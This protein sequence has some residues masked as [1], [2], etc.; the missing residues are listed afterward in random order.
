MLTSFQF[1][2]TEYKVNIWEGQELEPTYGYL[3]VDTETHL[4][5]EWTETPD[6]VTFQVFDGK[7]AYYLYPYQVQDFLILH[8]D[9][10]LVFHN[11]PF[12]CDVICKLV[13]DSDFF[14][15]MIDNEKIADTA[16]LYRLVKLS[17][18]GYVPRRYNLALCTK[19]LLFE[20]LD[21]DEHLRM[22]WGKYENKDFKDIP[23]D[24]LAYGAK[25]VAATYFLYNTLKSKIP[26]EPICMKT[27][28]S[29][30]IQVKGDLALSRI[31]K[32][33]IGTNPK[34]T[35]EKLNKFNDQLKELSYRLGNWGWVRGMKGCNEAFEAACK[36]LGIYDLLPKTRDASEKEFEEH[37]SKLEKQK[38][39]ES[40]DKWSDRVFE[41]NKRKEE[42]KNN[43][44]NNTPVSS[45]AED[46]E[47]YQHIEFIKDYVRY[48]KLEKLTSFLKPL[49]G[50]TRVHPRYN[51]IMNTGRTSCSKPNVQQLPREG[52]I[53]EVFQAP[54]NK[55]LVIADYAALELATLAQVCFTK[56]GESV[57][58]DRI[59]EGE[60]LHKYYASVLYSKDIKDINKGE[61]QSAKAANFGFPGGLGLKT[62]ITFAK[63]YDL[64]LTDDEAAEMKDAWFSAFPEME[65][66]MK[67]ALGQVT[68][69]T[70]RMRG[71]TTFCAE[72][73]PP[74]QGL[75]SDGAKLALYN[76]EK[77]GL[78]VV[79]F[80][81]DELVIEVDEKDAKEKALLLEKIMVDSMKEVTPDV[82][83]GVE[84]E[85]SKVYKK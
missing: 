81:H 58:K 37:F 29:M 67:D 61:R 3:A 23:E 53:R 2:A 71:N 26:R 79:A 34:L 56:Y 50:Q 33:G 48:H 45:K 68:T 38:K 10:E 46:L 65:P 14:F 8:K 21:K 40:L 35:E 82:H 44:M 60:D 4:V 7:T 66:Y 12:D 11:F 54:E 15:N 73:N 83:I 28:L 80:V 31:Y 13:G 36:T 17:Q 78:K 72:K 77:A 41:L 22:E 42:L 6:I 62:F 1:I 47:P 55:T 16:L 32:R 5:D 85:I 20:E 75:A 39:N 27:L 57:M 43:F 84:Y 76:A 74:F 59:N 63:G 51:T 25:D 52:G 19:E 69:L 9:T 70:G 49:V 30:R 64:T 18:L 24:V